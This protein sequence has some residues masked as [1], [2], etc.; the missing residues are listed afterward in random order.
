MSLEV[1]RSA[2][3][4]PLARGPFW[5]AAFVAAMLS[6]ADKKVAQGLAAAADGAPVALGQRLF[7]EET[8]GGNGRTCN[9]CHDLQQFGTITPELVQ[10]RYAEDPNDPLFRDIDSDQGL[11]ESY[12][13]LLHQATIRVAMELPT[14]DATGLSVRRCD[15]PEQTTVFLHR[16]NPS[17]FNVALERHLMHDGRDGADLEQQAL[18]AVEAHAESGRPPTKL[19][20][21]AIAEFQRSLFSHESV[22]AFF[23]KG[24][25]PR[26]PAG[27]TPAEVRGRRF[28]EPQ[29]HC[30]LCHSGPMLNRTSEFHPDAVNAAVEGALLS[31]SENPQEEPVYWC[32][33]DPE[34]N[35]IV[36]GPGGSPTVFDHPVADPGIAI[37]AGTQ[38]FSLPDGTEVEISNELLSEE[39]RAFGPL[40]KIPTLWGVANTAPYFH[41]NSAKTLE[42]LLTR[43]NVLFEALPNLGA[44]LSEEDKADIIAYL[45]LL[46]FDDR[47][48]DPLSE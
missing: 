10:R 16:G 18:H 42:E 41:D 27:G 43:Y 28:F 8:F 17:V 23:D 13:R 35:R 12:D 30:G 33:V 11:G 2:G 9:T 39:L 44:V 1:A 22:R 40:F 25:A 32:Y 24:V 21:A 37:V 31:C 14:H 15:S 47:S 19:E 5:I 38:S 29:S 7:I 48:R 46:S 26:L 4:T 45:R 34:T 6:V 36:P 20:R 3:L